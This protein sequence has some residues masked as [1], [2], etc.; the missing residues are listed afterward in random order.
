[1]S[2]RVLTIFFLVFISCKNVTKKKIEQQKVDVS[3]TDKEK[4]YKLK[5][6]FR[7]ED[8][9]IDYFGDS[10]NK[11]RITHIPTGKI[12]LGEK[13]NV[14]I[15]NAIQALEKLKKE[16]VFKSNSTLI[17]FL[18]NPIDLQKFKNKKRMRFTTSVTNG[19]NYYFN[20]KINDSI[21]YGYYY[22][23]ENFTNPKKIDEIVV[24]KYGEN[25]HSYEDE[26]EILIEFKIFNK[27]SD[28]GKANLIGLSKTDLESKFGAYY[29]TLN[30]QIIYSNKNKVLILTLDNSKVISFNYIKLNTDRINQDLISQIVK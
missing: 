22:S 8:I 4:Y 28:L 30:N 17:E 24:F 15:K 25:K 7:D 9:Q 3:V 10:F 19:T 26:T 27:D 11:I 5:S 20:P 16:L 6:Y 1:M 13:Y 12:Q 2:I 21:F 14:Q 29:L 18:K 23:N